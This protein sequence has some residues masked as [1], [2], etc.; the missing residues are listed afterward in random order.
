MQ[1][2]RFVMSEEDILREYR[3]AKFPR[4]QIKILADQNLVSAKVMRE[5]IILRLGGAPALRTCKRK[6]GFRWTPERV[7]AVRKMAARKM[8]DSEIGEH[9]GCTKSSIRQLRY[10]YG[11]PIGKRGEGRKNDGENAE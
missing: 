5:F 3:E 2:I 9:M 10:A 4:E 1:G 6:N 7:E 11:I 8:S